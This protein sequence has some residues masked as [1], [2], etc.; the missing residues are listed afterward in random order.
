MSGG[1][2]EFMIEVIEMFQDAAPGSLQ[3]IMVDLKNANFPQLRASVHKLKPSAQM[4]GH[5]ELH[6]LAA[7]I[8]EQCSAMG[9]A[10]KADEMLHDNVV[11]FCK[12]T[13]ALLRELEQVVEELR[14][15]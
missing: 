6:Q 7:T 4:L 5:T 9:D 3:S 11:K 14:A 1:D 10:D 15:R 12:E 8:E 2:T 13:N